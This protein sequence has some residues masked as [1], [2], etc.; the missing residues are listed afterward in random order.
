MKNPHAVTEQFE[1]G[2]A[3]YTGAEHAVATTSCTMGIFLALQFLKRN[4][5]LPFVIECPRYTYIGVAQSIIHAG[6]MI[7]WTDE[8]WQENGFYRLRPTPV[9]DTARW[10]S[11]DMFANTFRNY[12][13]VPEIMAVTSHHWSKTLGVQQG[14]CI[15]TDSVEARNWLRMARMDGRTPGVAPS[16]DMPIIGW[17]AYLSP[18]V[19]AT[20]LMRLSFLPDV[21]DPLPEPNYADLS[22]YRCFKPYTYRDDEGSQ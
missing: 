6:A 4:R 19:A 7:R 20:G 12:A 14:G 10:F 8:E 17:H 5:R 11:R 3:E 21:N 9:I 1:H 18:E 22:T 16:V 2:V 13:G 15:L